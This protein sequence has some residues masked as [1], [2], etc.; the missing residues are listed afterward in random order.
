MPVATLDACV[1]YK[2]MLT[3]LLLW[4][5][6]QGAFDP[7]W[8]DEIHDEWSRNLAERLPPEKIAY[9]RSEMEKAFVAANV[10]PRPVLIST[11]QGLCRTAAQRKDAHVVATAVDAKA[12]VI[13]TTNVKD[14]DPDILRHYGLTKQRPDA[15]LVGLLATGQAQVLAGVQ[16]H[17]ASLKRTNPTVGQYL[18]DLASPKLEVPWFSR[19]L[20]AHTASI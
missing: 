4:I 6:R 13:V 20:E 12:D 15:F 14:F 8:S 19:S 3:D 1:L 9:R 10:Q 11:I 2:G 7:V 17:R 5:A 18:T 16:A